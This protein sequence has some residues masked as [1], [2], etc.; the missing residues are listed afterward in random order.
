MKFPKCLISAAAAGIMLL[1]ASISACAAEYKQAPQLEFG[2]V[3]GDKLRVVITNIDEYSD[4]T[5]FDIYVSSNKL[6]SCSAAELKQ[7]GGSFSFTDN[8][9]R[10]LKPNTKY[11]VTAAATFSDSATAESSLAEKTTKYNFVTVYGGTKL[12]KLTNGKMK[13]VK[14]LK[15]DT[16][17]RGVQTD[18]AGND[19]AG[20][21]KGSVKCS[22]LRI[23]LPEK[24]GKN[25]NNEQLYKY[26]D[27]YIKN[28]SGKT[29]SR[30]STDSARNLVRNYA[31]KMSRV[32]DQ[33]YVL[34]GEKFSAKQLRSDCSGLT[35][36]SMLQAGIYL[37][38]N[39]AEQSA[40]Y[41]AQKGKVIFDNTVKTGRKNGVDIYKF[42]D[43]NAS[44][45][46]S[47]LKNGDLLFF[48]C[49]TNN[50]QTSP[51]FVQDGIGHVAMYIGGG[52]M[53]HFTSS[54]GLTNNPCRI[55]SLDDYQQRH[56]KVAKAVRIIY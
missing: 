4:D 16:V 41:S 48:I 28:S 22:Y 32:P 6:K 2:A 12:Y 11:T 23:T 14:T 55:E 20:K 56:L 7:N 51:E 9:K 36:Q 8:K 25:A 45:D 34:C 13:A 40:G 37:T 17:C 1:S 44:V 42:K 29:F 31:V 47:S 30:K 46:I 50:Q 38:H 53:V 39:A 54:Y 3:C 27:Y 18:A 21:P 43:P 5:Q 33:K 10:M 52:K 26:T 15:S 35:K 19:T 49:N 24:D